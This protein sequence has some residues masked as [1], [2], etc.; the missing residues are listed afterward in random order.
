MTGSTTAGSFVASLGRHRVVAV[1]R[2][3]DADAARETARACIA[4]GLGLIE[5]T[6]TTPDAVA[7]VSDLAASAPDGVLVGAGTVLDQD[8]VHAVVD[9]GARFLVSPATDPDVVATAVA[10]GVP[11]VPGAA[12]ASEIALG[13]RLGAPVVKVFPAGGLGLSFLKSVVA[14]MP[15]VPLLPS[16]GISVAQVPQWLAA[17][18]LAVAIG[19]ELDAAHASG[20]AD[21]VAALAATAAATAGQ[22]R[23]THRPHTLGVPS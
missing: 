15:Q 10:A 18:A 23:P 8:Q 5:I 11:F 2:H 3:H 19:S 14:V 13:R 6:L 21:A 4:G 17:G 12:T 1:V 20:G 22:H 9:A 16:G 7:L